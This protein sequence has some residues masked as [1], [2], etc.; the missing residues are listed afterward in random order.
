[1]S[2]G[3]IPQQPNFHAPLF[4]GRPFP[5]L[6][7]SAGPDAI[8]RFIEFFTANI[9][10]PN[11]RA[12]YARAVVQ[13]LDWAEKHHLQLK[14]IVPFHVAGYIEQLADRGTRE[15]FF[16]RK[17]QAGRRY[18]VK[19]ATTALDAPSIKQHLAAI[20]ML[21]DY[22]VTGQIV[23]LNPAASVR[24]PKHVVKKGK[25]PVLSA[26]DA[27]VLLD[28]IPIT[29]KVVQNGQVV[30][31]PDLLGLRDRALIGLMVFSFARVSAV[32]HME[33]G[34]YYQSGKR[35]WIRLHEKGGK[36]HEVPVHHKAEGYLDAYLGAAGT[37][38]QKKTP[39]FRSAVGKSNTFSDRPMSRTDALLMVK[40]RVAAAGLPDRVCCHTFRATGIT[41]FLEAG[42]TI[43][44]AQAIA[45]HE[46]P[47]TTKLYDRTKDEITLDEI[48]RIRI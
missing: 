17:S 28:S 1:M 16:T 35:F 40:R 20:R 9:R 32:V 42:G 8:R 46:S 31:V 34:D 37:Q 4:A 23:P 33:V 24:G 19:T 47:R 48:E 12:A 41:A 38:E 6:I 26:E 14:G 13:F 30:E 27:R 11:T 36:F 10:N 3:L 15:R 44:N 39:L 29:R 7:A 22:L 21:F 25:T 45:A 5:T 18:Q 2:Q 43:E